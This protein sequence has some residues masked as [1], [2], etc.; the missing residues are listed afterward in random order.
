MKIYDI[1]WND[2]L[3]KV[4]NNVTMLVYDTYFKQVKPVD[5]KDE[6]FILSVPSQTVA[7]VITGRYSDLLV[8]AIKET[9]SGAKN[10]SLTIVGQEGTIFSSQDDDE[11][12]SSPIDPNYTFDNFVVGESNRYLYAAAKAVSSNPGSTYNPLYIYG[13]TGLGKTHIMHAIANEIKEKNPEIKILYATCEKFTTDLISRIKTGQAYAGGQNFRDKYRKVDVL[14]IDDIQ[15]LAK[16][17]TTQEEFFH[18][19]NELYSQNKQIILSSDCRPSEI[20]TLAER[21]RTRFEGGLMAQV[22]APDIETKIA[23]LQKKAE[24]KKAIISYEVA[25]FIAEHSNN[26]IRSLEGLLNKVIF[27]SLLHEKPIDLDLAMLTLKQTSTVDSS[28]TLTAD[29]I[30]QEVCKFFNISKADITGKRRNKEIAEP[31]MICAYLMTDMLSLPLVAI[32]K[33]LG[34]RDYTTIIHARDTIA[35][36]IKQSTKTATQVN[37]IKNL[38]LKK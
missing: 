19:F 30:I 10:F 21:L 26:D 37:D 6:T 36:R 14:I 13:D 11:D 3:S 31:R 23:I 8:S 24:N 25:N 32:G 38:I 20:E 1:L 7:D 34:G 5:I 15:F 33:S 2:I 17:Q 29:D 22:I 16:K 27:A 35:E 28:E 9:N 12:L 18:T 4:E